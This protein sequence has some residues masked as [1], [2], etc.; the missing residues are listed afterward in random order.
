MRRLDGKWCWE[1]GSKGEPSGDEGGFVISGSLVVVNVK[2]VSRRG[3]E[4]GM[5]ESIFTGSD[6]GDD[7]GEERGDKNA[8]D[9][10]E[11]RGVGWCRMAADVSICSK[12]VNFVCRDMTGGSAGGRSKDAG[13][14]AVSLAT[15]NG[16]RQMGDVAM[17]TFTT[18]DVVS[19]ATMF[20][21]M[22]GGG[23]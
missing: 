23:V 5:A 6:G 16:D 12:G 8:G 15:C 20:V 1:E 17:S 7:D 14:S 21:L 22:A 11:D 9:P 10:M 19:A 18:S 3:K 13:S 2:L 4:E